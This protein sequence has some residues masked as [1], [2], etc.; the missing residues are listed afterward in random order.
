MR[1]E[2]V[3]AQRQIDVLKLTSQGYSRKEIA[4]ILCYEEATIKRDRMAMVKKLGARNICHAVTL[5]LKCGII[6]QVG[7]LPQKVGDML[8]CQFVD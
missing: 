6:C 2:K 5:G 1:I 7:C 8:K 4:G 3:M